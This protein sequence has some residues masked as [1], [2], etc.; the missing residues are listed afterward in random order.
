MEYSP[1]EF[2]KQLNNEILELVPTTPLED[3]ISKIDK[4]EISFN[5]YRDYV[6]VNDKDF[7]WI[8][9]FKNTVNTIRTIISKPKIHLRT[10]KV[11]LNSNIASKVDNLGMR[12]TVKDSRLWKKK[13]N[14]FSPEY[15][16]ANVYE[17]ELPIYENK[18]VTLL[19][20]KMSLFIS[21]QL[22]KLYEKTGALAGFV[23]KNNI[24]LADVESIKS[25]SYFY[26]EN[27][28]YVFN[29]SLPL[30]T[31]TGNE[32]KKYIEKL[33]ELKIAINKVKKS[34]FYSLCMK[35]KHL[36]DNEVHPTNVLTM[37][38]DYRI[39]Y[40]FYKKLIKFVEKEHKSLLSK[41]CYENY[42]LLNIIHTLYARGYT[43]KKKNFIATVEND[44]ISLKELILIK[45]PIAFSITTQDNRI[46][47]EVSLIYNANKFIKTLNLRDK[48]TARYAIEVSPNLKHMFFNEEKLNKHINET[49]KELCDEGYTNAFVIT[50]FKS[51]NHPQSIMVSPHT[52]KLDNNILNLLRSFAIFI[53]GDEFIYSRKCPVC[54]SFL[55]NFDNIEYECLN[56][57]ANYSI[58]SSGKMDEKRDMI[59][60]KR[61]D[62]QANIHNKED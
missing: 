26:K 18:F 46:F 11:L 15:I 54:G 21:M 25:S 24:E 17:D 20:N 19:I 47:I 35:A 5:A 40:E 28:E 49:I 30:L 14:E 3:I 53:E 61:I 48:R 33:T 62:N 51:I 58:L 8:E 44:R 4:N 23:D 12:M 57:T 16:Y 9:D 13:D 2:L 31:P 32:V 27:D 60:I 42:V 39:C 41:H 10:D 55:V 50:P 1:S 56:C 38:P 45:E 52:R 7:L 36:S 43:I 6:A 22:L 29:D 37:H 34:E 59:W